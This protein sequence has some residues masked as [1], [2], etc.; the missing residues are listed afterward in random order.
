[1]NAPLKR[2][3][4]DLLLRFAEIVG[5]RFAISDPDI[6]K[7]YLVEMR[8]RYVG[9]AALVLRPGSVEEVSRILRLAG[10]ARIGIVPQGGN[11]G[12]VAGQVPYEHGN[13]IVLSLARLNR[14]RDVDPEGNTMVAEAGVTLAEVRRAADAV[15][16]FFPLGLPS[17]GTCQI[18][19]NVTTNAG[20]AAVLAYGTMRDLTLGVEVVLA[21]GRVWNGL[22]RLRK[23]NTGYDLKDLFVG[24]EGTLGVVTAASLK[25]FPKPRATETA[26]VGLATPEAAISLLNVA[27]AHAGTQVVSFELLPRIAIEFALRH[28]DG[29]RDPFAEPH[30]WYVLLELASGRADS[31]LDALMEALLGEALESGIAADAVVAQSLDQRKAFWRMRED[32]NDIQ[33]REG[34]SIKH[35]V[36]VPVAKVP[37]FLREAI[38]AV[39]RVV[40]GARPVP[41]GHVGDGN[42]H[43]N[44]SQPAGAD[45][46]AFLARWEEMN[47][48][49]HEVVARYDGS[50]SAEH[51]IG[52]MKKDLLPS[53]KSEVEMDLMRG[54]KTLLD[55]AGILNPG[56]LL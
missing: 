17:E 10:E 55:P 5:E 3:T 4:P 18:G 38:A 12:L 30:A 27:L 14:I 19:G 40:P 28:L 20:G 35:D 6:M 11:T 8:D 42:I 22:R 24:S 47:D 51:G 7:P 9:K 50:I 2:P 45:K 26:F 48:A 56:K 52:R 21:D 53:V 34:G 32:M 49:V 41:F 46:A 33:V 15:D 44:V 54:I 1:M 43:F 25:L 39:E 23:D 36:S 31:G 13:E 37:A 29:A 16:R